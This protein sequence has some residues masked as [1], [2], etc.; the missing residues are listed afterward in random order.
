MKV[1]VDVLSTRRTGES[2]VKLW[3]G[4]ASTGESGVKLWSGPGQD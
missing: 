1:E 2:G 3:S 4:P